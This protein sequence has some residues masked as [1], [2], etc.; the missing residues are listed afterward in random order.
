MILCIPLLYTFKHS[1]HLFYSLKLWNFLLVVGSVI[2]PNQIFDRIKVSSS[3]HIFPSSKMFRW[4][5]R[6]IL[7]LPVQ[8]LSFA[9]NKF[10]C[11]KTNCKCQKW[12]NTS[13]IL[14]FLSMGHSFI[15]SFTRLV[16]S[17]RSNQGLI[18]ILHIFKWTNYWEN[19][20]RM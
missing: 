8:K 17:F 7:F 12:E 16:H 19:S 14:H 5:V 11:W 9:L 1:E 10:Y 6:L 3:W 18:Y 15:Q 13:D 4:H 20:Q 2:S